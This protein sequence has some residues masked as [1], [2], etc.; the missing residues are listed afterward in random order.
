MAGYT[1][2][3][4]AVAY[5][6]YGA[7]KQSTGTEIYDE[8][9]PLG[10]FVLTEVDVREGVDGAVME[11]KGVDRSYL[12][13]KSKWYDPFTIANGTNLA[14]AIGLILTDRYSSVE[15]D[16]PEVLNTVPSVTLGLNSGGSGDDPWS[17]VQKLASAGGYDLYFNGEG[18]AVLSPI[19]D[20]T[21]VT[22]VESYEENQ[23]AVLL[24]VARRLSTEQTFN[25]VV[26]TGEGTN[27]QPP[28]RAIAWDEDPASPTYRFGRFGERPEFLSSPLVV[29]GEDALV[30][31][32][33]RLSQIKGAEE[34]VEWEAITDPSLEAGDV[35]LIRNTGTRLDKVLVVDKLTVPL[36]ASSGMKATARTVRSLVAGE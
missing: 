12:V 24:N 8:E 9:V 18:M 1:Y 15:L 31:A 3:T 14:D 35:V 29:T 23:D 36:T 17:D 20:P 2:A 26:L 11:V 16:F 21:S 25:G 33:A 13:A 4:L 34:N 7:M 27:V 22:P 32:T 19:A 10:V 5:S 28:V 6:T 30:A